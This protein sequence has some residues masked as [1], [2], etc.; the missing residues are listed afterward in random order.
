MAPIVKH[1]NPWAEKRRRLRILTRV[2]PSLLNRLLAPLL[3][4]ARLPFILRLFV[5]APAYRQKFSRPEDDAGL[6]EVKRTFLLVGV[7]YQELRARFGEEIA[8]RT[9]HRFIFELGNAVQRQAY[10]PPPVMPR[11]WDWFHREHEAQMAEGFI[12][13][14]E[15]DGIRHSAQQV[16]LHITRCRFYEAFRDMGHAGLTEAFCRSDETV[17]NEYSAAMFFHRGSEVPNTIAR[18]APR[19]TFVY[20]RRPA[21]SQVGTSR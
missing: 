11:D 9:A 19:C 2:V 12:R 1:L 18:G 7:L 13:N 8:F 21:A 10:F 3:G 17:F 15:N 4:A 5:R 20:D 16:S 14:N 6:K